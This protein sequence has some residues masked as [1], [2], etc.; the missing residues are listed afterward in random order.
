M[1]VRAGGGAT[2][3]GAGGDAGGGGG[4]SRGDQPAAAAGGYAR[5]SHGDGGTGLLHAGAARVA[6]HSVGAAQ[7]RLRSGLSE[8]LRTVERLRHRLEVGQAQGMR[9]LGERL[10]RARAALLRQDAGHRLRLLRGE[11]A[12][13]DARLARVAGEQTRGLRGR[14]EALAGRLASLSPVAVLSRGYAL[15]FDAEGRLVKQAA[16][17]RGG[18]R[19]RLRLAEGSV[20]SRAEE[21]NEE[22]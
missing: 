21:T 16:E 17:V 14:H 9:G 22:A 8:R 13:L 19:L 1:P 12:Q 7:A 15:V 18:E 4:T 3:V 6:A 5:V 2:A 11:W 10:E 20:W